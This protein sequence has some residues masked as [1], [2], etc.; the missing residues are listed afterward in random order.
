MAECILLKGGGSGL[1]PDE[2]TATP[3]KV[4]SGYTA[5]VKG[6]DEPAGGTMPRRV[7]G[8][9]ATSCVIW[10]GNVY[11][12]FPYGYY[13][14]DF[15]ATENEIRAPQAAVVNAIGLTAD[16]LLAG[17]N[18]AGVNGVATSDAN[19]ESG[20]ILSGA[21]AY[22]NGK[23][24]SGSIPYQNADTGTGEPHAW[25]TQAIGWTGRIHLGVRNGYFLNGVD[26]IRF[27]C[28]EYN[29]SNIKKGVNIMGVIGEFE[30]YSAKETFLV[31]NGTNVDMDLTT[32]TGDTGGSVWFNQNVRIFS[33]K[34]YDL[35]QYD[36][37]V[38][39]VTLDPAY[40][41][42]DNVIIGVNDYNSPS[43]TLGS[44]RPIKT[45]ERIYGPN[46]SY[47]SFDLNKYR[48]Y[49]KISV[50]GKPGLRIK[51]L[52]LKKF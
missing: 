38:F 52:S 25:A 4:L 50:S 32:G 2:L 13:G 12:R 45:Y 37:L 31:N 9:Q 28:P 20:H 6:S 7:R 39:V 42:I 16:K 11:Y 3:D 34:E 51:Y 10:E 46:T 33:N 1:D 36:S 44:F 14:P 35:S 48:G 27:D 19:A 5:G 40:S 41:Y 49:G 24:I 22:V 18:V 15:S 26:W 21:S 43:D 8:Q 47:L 29:P 30:G 23:K 17:Q